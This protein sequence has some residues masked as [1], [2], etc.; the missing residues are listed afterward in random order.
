MKIDLSGD[1]LDPWLY[2]RDNGEGAAL[3]ALQPLLNGD[4]VPETD[5]LSNLIDN[6]TPNQNL[7]LAYALRQAFR[8]EPDRAEYIERVLDIL[9]RDVPT[10]EDVTVLGALLLEARQ[11]I[12]W[13]LSVAQINV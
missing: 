9:G 12:D 8:G 10:K 1:I 3:A 13:F 11:D 6:M 7:K 2:D 5:E 4:K